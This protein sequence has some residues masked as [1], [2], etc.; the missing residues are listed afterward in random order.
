MTSI[1]PPALHQFAIVARPVDSPSAQSGREHILD[2]S[3]LTDL[4]AEAFA[5]AHRV[6]GA[7]DDTLWG[8]AAEAAALILQHVAAVC[9]VESGQSDSETDSSASHGVSRDHA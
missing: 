4:V 6:H 1:Y 8:D 3:E 2:H 9:G 7:R 5:E